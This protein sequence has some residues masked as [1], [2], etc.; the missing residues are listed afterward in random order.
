MAAL[1]TPRAERLRSPAVAWLV[2]AAICIG[3]VGGWL[4]WRRTIADDRRSQLDRDAADVAERVFAQAAHQENVLRSVAGL[5]NASD[6]VSPAAFRSFLTA[7][8]FDH[9]FPA[10]QAIIWAAR[11]DD[12]GYPVVLD[13]SRSGRSARGL[14]AQSL[15][16]LAAAMSTALASGST[17][18]TNPLTLPGE[19]T[20]DGFAL[21]LPVFRGGAAPESDWGRRTAIRGYL[22]ATVRRS[23]FLDGLVGPTSRLHHVSVRTGGPDALAQV[24]TGSV[25]GETVGVSRRV[26]GRTWTVRSTAPLSAYDEGRTNAADLLMLAGVT[27]GLLLFVLLRLLGHGEVRARRRATELTASLREAEEAQRALTLSAPIGILRL[28]PDGR[29]VDGNPRLR[30][31]LG[32][33]EDEP[34]DDVPAMLHPDDAPLLA[35]AWECAVRTG[36]A[37]QRLRVQRGDTVA[38]VDCSVRELLDDEGRRTGWVGTVED[39]TGEAVWAAQAERLTAI[40]EATTDYVLI[41]DKTGRVLFLNDAAV[42]LTHLS[43][44]DA[45]TIETVFP[46]YLSTYIRDEVLPTTLR[47]GQ[48]SGDLEMLTHDGGAVPVSLV[49]LAHRGADGTV[50]YFSSIARDMT[51]RLRVEEALTHQQLHDPLTG[52]A[53]R[54]LLV[55]RLD[56]AMGRAD[57]LGSAPAVAF[58]DLD[59]FTLVNDSSG[60]DAGDEVLREV[61]RRLQGVLREG[62]TAARFG[63]DE[64]VVLCEGLRGDVEALEVV[65]RLRSAFGRPIPLGEAEI[66]VTA[67]IGIAVVDHTHEKAAHVLRDAHAA[68]SRAKERGPD[69]VELFDDHLR[70]RAINRLRTE[71]ELHRA[72]EHGELRVLYQPEVCLQRGVV[73]AVE[74]LVRWHHPTRGLL[75]PAEFV[76]L[77]ES[78]GLIREVGRFVLAEAAWQA[79][80]W[81]T[82]GPDGQPVTVWVNLS[83]A[84]VA[85]PDLVDTVAALLSETRAP[86]GGLGIEITETALLE[87]LDLMAERVQALRD[88]GVRVAI[89]DFGTGFSSLTYLRRLP[90]DALKIDRSFVSDLTADGTDDAPAAGGAGPA[91][92]PASGR[93]IVAAIVS[94][95]DALGL[96]AIAEGVE[97]PD[98]LLAVAELGCS[99]AQGWFFSKPVPRQTVDALLVG[100]DPPWLQIPGPAG[101]EP[102]PSSVPVPRRAHLESG[103]NL[104]V[105]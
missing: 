87:D 13:H 39:V 53:N 51:E 35:A 32:L 2:L 59:N 60:H 1:S 92:G 79:A 63:A 31:I 75:S 96:E 64:F 10:M 25:Q 22:I 68:L 47:D 56:H 11:T 72:L 73:V 93:A 15:P 50:E 4:S 30:A 20:V 52:L 17:V 101:T 55:D 66:H 61:S 21:V 84:E 16:V 65:D 81:R 9:R 71:R 44:G 37:S 62:D 6:E 105:R 70:E 85:Q 103:A 91:S 83:P 94:I 29:L 95:A 38:W 97:T 33:A 49:L 40:A 5:L 80:R 82:S 34:L 54:V 26:L 41:S 36:E 88:L 42:R 74:S 8:D 24:G 78:I 100:T 89:D 27:V 46:P 3:S 14:D 23:V 67:G 28:D 45:T 90:V 12:A 57:R 76:P 19:I 69:Q 102:T 99:Y 43:P 98:Q 104:S 58:V 18:T 48:W 7:V 86:R 77:A